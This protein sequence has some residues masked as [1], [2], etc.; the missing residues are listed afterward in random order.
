MYFKTGGPIFIYEES[1]VDF[2]LGLS[3]LSFY[4]FNSL[5]CACIPVRKRY[6]RKKLT[7]QNAVA[8]CQQKVACDKCDKSLQKQLNN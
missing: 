2:Y 4:H 1:Y 8:F 6:N 5:L 3:I 7:R